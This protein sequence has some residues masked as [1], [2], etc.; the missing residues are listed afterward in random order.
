M[1]YTGAGPPDEAPRVPVLQIAPG[2]DGE[3]WFVQPARLRRFRSIQG[4]WETFTE[5]GPCWAV[6]LAGD[7][8]LVGRYANRGGRQDNQTGLLGLSLLDLRGG[9]WRHLPAQDGLPHESVTAVTTDG[10]DVWL[11]GLGFIA[12]IGPDYQLRKYAYVRAPSVDHI[13]VAGGWV[14]AQFDRHLH[15]VRLP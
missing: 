8:L 14:W 9:Q 1:G 5:A 11:G 12:C 2:R 13:Q 15:R 7:R 10:Q 4:L 6:A 3:V